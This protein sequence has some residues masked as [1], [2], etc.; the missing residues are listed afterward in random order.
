M[1][2]IVNKIIFILCVFLFFTTLIYGAVEIS[3]LYAKAYEKSTQDVVYSVAQKDD[4]EVSQGDRINIGETACTIGYID[5]EKKQAHL[6]GHCVQ[7]VGEKA[8]NELWEEIG[9]VIQDDLPDHNTRYWVQP[10]DTAIV[11]IHDGW[12]VKNPFSGDGVAGQN[13]IYR[14]Q[15]VCSYG[16]TTASIY[17]GRIKVKENGFFMFNLQ[18]K[19]Q[20]GDSGGP[21]WIP[22]KGV[23]GVLSGVE[24]G[25]YTASMIDAK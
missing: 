7:K 25:V 8:Y 3:N 21:V 2:T 1:H 15:K 12:S 11:Q 14:W 20:G 19:L 17:C 9:T 22:Q 13:D 4:H 23:V 5:N 10:H 6:S 16:A 24:N 18:G